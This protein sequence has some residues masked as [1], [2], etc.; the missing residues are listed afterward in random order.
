MGHP[1]DPQQGLVQF[2]WSEVGQN[3]LGKSQTPSFTI[4]LFPLFLS[5]YISALLS[6][7]YVIT[8]YGAMHLNKHKIDKVI[9]QERGSFPLFL[10]KRR[11]G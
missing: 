10:L 4:L 1:F 5:L 2:C 11:A 8:K 7:A 6:G 9:L 3:W